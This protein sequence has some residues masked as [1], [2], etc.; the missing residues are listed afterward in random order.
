MMEEGKLW[1]VDPQAQ[2]RFAKAARAAG[3]NML[4]RPVTPFTSV[5][6]I[7][8]TLIDLPPDLQAGH[9]S[10]HARNPG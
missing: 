7:F 1:N 6:G 10:L 2:M 8:R 4:E 3:L 9:I 5:T